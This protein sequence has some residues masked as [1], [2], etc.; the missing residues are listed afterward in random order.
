MTKTKYWLS[1]LAISVVLVAGSL[2]VSP[3]AIAGD[4]DDDDDDDDKERVSVTG[5]YSS[6]IAV[7]PGGVAVLLDTTG[8]GTLSTV[9]VAMNLPC[10]GPGTAPTGYVVVAG[11]AGVTIPSAP[12]PIITSAAE[13]T[14]F[15]G[16]AAGT[17]IFHATA[18]GGPPGSPTEITDVVIFNPAGAPPLP[19]GTTFT[20]TGTYN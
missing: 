4:D 5:T 12:V 7:P 15:T 6:S 8:S 10:G 3:I 9:H 14:G 11:V 17:C 20:V 13:N 16:T 19:P 18:S 1:L 2:A